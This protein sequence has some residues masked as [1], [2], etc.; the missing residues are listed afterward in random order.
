MLYR[1]TC[2]HHRLKKTLPVVKPIHVLF[3]CLGNICR[4]PLAEAVA[5]RHAEHRKLSDHFYFCS[6]GT[7]DWNLGLPPDPGAIKI[8]HQHDLNLNGHHARQ[9]TKNDIGNWHWFVAM[10]T[11]NRADL[12]ALG[13][14]ADSI[15][16]MRQFEEK[17]TVKEISD[18]YGGSE[19]AFTQVY[20]ILEKNAGPLMDYLLAQP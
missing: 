7:G 19:A 12:M 5:R 18:P 3:V 2:N 10:D 16:L 4:S 17:D 14:P 13:A 1:H 11:Q 15:L 20:E 9:I 8:A 6:A